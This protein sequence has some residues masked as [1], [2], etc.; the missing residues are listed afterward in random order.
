MVVY[1]V[2]KR[3]FVYVLNAHINSS[4]SYPFAYYM[5][6]FFFLISSL[7]IDQPADVMHVFVI[8]FIFSRKTRKFLF[9]FFFFVFFSW[10]WST[11]E[12]NNHWNVNKHSLYVHIHYVEIFLFNAR[13]LIKIEIFL[14]GDF[15]ERNIWF[16]NWF[17]FLF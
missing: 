6:N 2:N 10:L 11:S 13:F 12:N 8:T 3:L 17:F 5:R 16:Y 7:F 15:T 9:Y 4:F 14:V 1:E